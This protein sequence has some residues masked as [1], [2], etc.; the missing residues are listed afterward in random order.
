MDEWGPKVAAAVETG[1]TSEEAEQRWHEKLRTEAELRAKNYEAVADKY[2]ELRASAAVNIPSP[3]VAGLVCDDETVIAGVA[4]ELA[5]FSIELSDLEIKSMVTGTS[6]F[7]DGVIFY[8]AEG[9]LKQMKPYFVHSGQAVTQN[10][11]VLNQ[12]TRWKKI[13]GG[14]K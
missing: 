8:V 1:L 4:R 6:V 7:C 10:N 13:S 5:S 2:L 3:A 9:R 11:E 14:K 12:I